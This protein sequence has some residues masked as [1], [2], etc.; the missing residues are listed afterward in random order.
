VKNEQSVEK[1]FN[2]RSEFNPKPVRNMLGL[3]GNPPSK[4]VLRNPLE[5]MRLANLL[6]RSGYLTIRD[7]S[8]L[9]LW[10]VPNP[11]YKPENQEAQNQY[12][13]PPG[14]RDKF[15]HR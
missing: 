15:L 5:K 10:R 3:D 13:P 12:D 4:L 7:I 11:D 6:Y 9:N 1:A 8:A 2:Y 14:A